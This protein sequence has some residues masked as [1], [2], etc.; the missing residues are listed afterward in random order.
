M[1]TIRLA[2]GKKGLDIHLPS[3]LDTTVIEP[4]S[5]KALKD[6]EISI[7]Y[8]LRNPFGCPPLREFVTPDTSIGIV[9][10][11]ITRPAPNDIILPAILKSL[12]HVPDEN[13]TL[14]I[15]LGS[16]RTNSDPEL[17]SMLGDS[18][19]SR[20]DIVQNDAFTTSTQECI[21]MT[22]KGHELW[23]NRQL[24]ECDIKILTG[25]I[26]PHFF[27]GFSGGAKAI[28]P[29]MAGIT[30]ILGNHGAEMIGH[31][32]A[33]WGQ[34]NGNPIWEEIQEI[35]RFVGRTFL[36]NV[37]L[38]KAK[39]ITGVY[40]GDISVAHSKGCDFVKKTSMVSSP[41]LYDIVITTN[42]GYPL[43]L[44][45]YQSV[46]GISA[47]ARIVR[48][49]G[50]II[51]AT[52]CWDGVPEHGLFSQMLK[53]AHSPEDLLAVIHKSEFHKQDQ[54]QVQILSQILLKADVYVYSH[55]LTEEQIK[56]AM[57]RPIS[58]IEGA[59]D[60]LVRQYGQLAKICILP[61]GPQTIPF[62]RGK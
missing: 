43:D 16:H 2:Y 55:K 38:N 62:L 51:I 50:A 23:L 3:D 33:T 48:D 52:E 10:S 30:T 29:G 6:P 19:F 7:D 13:I 20:F 41:C 22:T 24:I 45:L 57:M 56:M 25:F 36:V 53:D 60:M 18:L 47:G 32:L 61:E 1:K 59:L 27:A 46:K 28:F 15:A 12:S 58:N 17:R 31:P 4:V 37:T 40:S 49:G 34:R 39:Q 42:A 21:G 44:N 35:T 11:D 26:E 9:V 14:F 5:T 8:S 54:W